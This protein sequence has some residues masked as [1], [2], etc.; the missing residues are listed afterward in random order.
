M[1]KITSDID[2]IKETLEV[3]YGKEDN[4]ICHQIILD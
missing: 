4:K 1:E 3:R 2:F